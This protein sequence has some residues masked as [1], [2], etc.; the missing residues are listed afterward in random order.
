MLLSAQMRQGFVLGLL[1]AFDPV[2]APLTMARMGATHLGSA[3][4]FFLAYLAA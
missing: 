4:P 2:E 1:D 3:V